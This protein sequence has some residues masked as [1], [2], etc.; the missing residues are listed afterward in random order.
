MDFIMCEA[1]R[2]VLVFGSEKLFL[3]HV[4]LLFLVSSVTDTTGNKISKKKN[5]SA[6]TDGTRFY[7]TCPVISTQNVTEVPWG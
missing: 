1:E 3:I 4:F 7:R 6:A 2:E 5:S